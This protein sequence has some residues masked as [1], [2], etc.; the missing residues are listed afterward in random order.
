MA[1]Y[2][3]SIDERIIL[4]FR[5]PD[6]LSDPIGAKWLEEMMRDITALGGVGL[7]VF[8]SFTV[9]I[10]LLIERYHR[11]ALI[12]FIFIASG[13]LL[14]FALKHGFSRP[15]PDIVAHGSYVYTSSF[16]SG[17]AMM[18]SL[19]YLSIA[20][21]LSHLSFR[22][23]IKTYFFVVALILTIAIGISRV[24]LG[25]HY[26]TDVIG[27]WVLGSGW[28]LLCYFVFRHLKTSHWIEENINEVEP[29][30]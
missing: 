13:I 6:N 7:L 22:R 23:R 30:E 16:P 24:Y 15:R 8:I 1:G 26:F 27:G 25:V 28:A 14:S 12:F 29:S 10:F 18:S 3:A 4:L 2:T 20:G 5:N 21:M 9:L 11:V 19:I 17:H